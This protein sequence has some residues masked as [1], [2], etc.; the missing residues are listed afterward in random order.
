VPLPVD[1]LPLNV[2]QVPPPVTALDGP[3]LAGATKVPEPVNLMFRV[4]GFRADANA[5]PPGLSV[6]MGMSTLI[7][8]QR[9]WA[10]LPDALWLADNPMVLSP[11]TGSLSVL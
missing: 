2:S 4:V 7:M 10:A 1:T 6:V 11:D 9:T 3:P 8:S 5:S